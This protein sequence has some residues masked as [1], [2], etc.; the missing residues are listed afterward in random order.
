MKNRK[1]HT[2]ISNENEGDNFKLRPAEEL[3]VKLQESESRLRL[4]IDATKLGTWDWNRERGTIYWSD[5]CKRI[6]GLRPDDHIS[7]QEFIERIDIADRLDVEAKIKKI[8][9]GSREGHIDVRY[10][11][12]K[13]QDNS[14]CWVRIQGRIFVNKNRTL[15][16]FIGTM[17]DITDTIR[18]GEQ[19]ALLAAII[20]SSND[21]IVAKTLDGII[22]TWNGASHKLFGYSPQEIIGESI[23]KII[24][25]DRKEE[26]YHILSKLRNGE[27]VEHYETKRLTKSGMLIDVSLTI[28]PIKDRD[29]RIIGISKIARDISEK[30][31]EDKRKNDFVA[32]VSHELKTPLT[33]ILLYTQLLVKKS[34]NAEDPS[35]FNMSTKIEAYVK[36]MISMI[37][38]YLGLS[39]IE[40]GKIDIRKTRFNLKSLADEVIEE[41]HLI[42][43]KHRLEIVGSADVEVYADLEKMRQVL[44]NLVGNAI[45]YSPSGGSVILGWE[46]H[47]DKLRIYVKDEGVGI[48]VEDQANLFKRFYRA[49]EVERKNIAGFGIGLYL[50]SE[51]LRL[52]GSRI[53]VESEPG[54][55]SV[56][57][58]HIDLN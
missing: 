31:Q 17:L 49:K 40:E 6:L 42:S 50:V 56:F 54:K 21:A 41:A 36:R 58:F 2:N 34:K 15:S 23:M 29:G 22:T 44:I 55:G 24:P 3:L 19:N 5:E 8:I 28:S 33:S 47:T 13:F 16:R 57:Y 14:P 26:E 35:F 51:L 12:R 32:M 46:G 37:I 1:K 7:F 11:I 52:H 30:K 48:S 4:A 39:R 20:T 45:K 43:S 38:D 10:K 9:R 25:D 18:S 53:E 27:S